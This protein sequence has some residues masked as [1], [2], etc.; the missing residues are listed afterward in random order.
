MDRK[1]C[2]AASNVNSHQKKGAHAQ[3]ARR[4]VI[5]ET[6]FAMLDIFQP[7][8]ALAMEDATLQVP[9]VANPRCAL[10]LFNNWVRDLLSS[11]MPDHC[12]IR[13]SAASND[14]VPSKLN[15]ACLKMFC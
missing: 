8:N 9:G 5:G 6:R 10:A 14:S 7:L 1:I 13:R 4:F 12:F 2:S 3:R 15:N 11:D